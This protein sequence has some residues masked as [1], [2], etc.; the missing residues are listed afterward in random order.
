L[1]PLSLSD[2][3]LI[4]LVDEPAGEGRMKLD[5]STI[6]WILLAVMALQPLLAGRWLTIKRAQAIRAIERS[7]QSRVITM[8]HRQEKR[9][10]FGLSVSRHIDLE[11]A[12]TI[13]GAIKET[14]RDRPIDLIIH[15][16]GGL[17][18]AAM[19]IARAV[20]AH[21][22]KVTVFVP[23]YAMSGGTL[24]ALAADQIVLGEFSVLGPIDPQIVGLP[25]ASIVKAR[26][27]KPIEHVFDLTLVL[28][29]V[30]EKALAQ[31]KRGAVELLTSHLDKGA[32]EEL[33]GKLAG[34]HWTH[35]YALTASEASGLGLP[36]S[37]NMPLEVI[38]LMKLYPQPVQRSGVEFLPLDVPTKRRALSTLW[39]ELRRWQ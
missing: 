10:L 28:A 15:T 35:D 22:A 11:D 2:V 29:D 31:V 20:E 17:V 36:V 19:Q 30:S 13:I 27:S 25:A 32:A 26:D 18:L 38:E 1:H 14:P 5:F 4:F 12:Q 33:A 23:V 9:S 3:R 24:I 21:P 37:V 34:G 7:R 8:I 6:F 39:G 16:P